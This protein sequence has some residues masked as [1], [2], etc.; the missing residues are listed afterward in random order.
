MSDSITFASAISRWIIIIVDDCGYWEAI[1][2][3]LMTLRSK[4]MSMMQE[5]SWIKG[6]RW[7]IASMTR[8]RDH[9]NEYH[10]IKGIVSRCKRSV[11]LIAAKFKSI[12]WPRTNVVISRAH[13]I[14]GPTCTYRESKAYV[15]LQDSTVFRLSY[16]LDR[17]GCH[18]FTTKGKY[19]P[20]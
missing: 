7:I 9:M 5:C 20:T 14:L 16:T 2:L 10:Y 3:E 19:V 13:T 8:A 18:T 6:Y 15:A 17:H 11:A 1:G 12:V 4:L